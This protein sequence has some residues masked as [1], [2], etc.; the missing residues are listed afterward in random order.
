VPDLDPYYRAASCVVAPIFA[1]GG[2]HFKVPQA[3]LYGLAL[4]ATP[5]AMEGFEGM[6]PG[7][8]PAPTQDPARFAQLV[9][10]ALGDPTDWP[11]DRLGAQRWVADSFSFDRTVATVKAELA[12]RVPA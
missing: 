7:L 9:I 1:S 8:L 6:P 5:R 12:R 3:L 10:D 2:L 11:G 4:V